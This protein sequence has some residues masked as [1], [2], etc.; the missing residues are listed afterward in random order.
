MSPALHTEDARQA[1]RLHV[2]DKGADVFRKHGPHLGWHELLRL[3][4]DRSCV[5]YPCAIA[6][7]AA[8]L[9]AG[10]F[11]HPVPKGAR[12]E[13][14]F[15]MYVH[16]VFRAQRDRVSWLV[17]YQLVLVN[18]GPFV[19]AEDAETFAA[20]ALGVSREEYYTTL[21]G[22]ADQVGEPAEEVA[23]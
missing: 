12:P 9:R 20:A 2:G 8:P 23:P 16:P 7:D 11:A 4:E 14:G 5:R 22:L 18:Y 15:V 17:L 6:F 19:S 13:D 1:L 10:E 3:L 21:C